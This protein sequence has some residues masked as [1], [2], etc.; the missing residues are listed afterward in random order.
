MAADLIIDHNPDRERRECHSPKQQNVC[1]GMI[2]QRVT[3]HIDKVDRL[4]E[5]LH[6]LSFFLFQEFRLF[7]PLFEFELEFLIER[8]SCLF[9]QFRSAARVALIIYGYSN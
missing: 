6:I 7:D 5:E 3:A 8:A 4:E 1:I 9:L 2:N